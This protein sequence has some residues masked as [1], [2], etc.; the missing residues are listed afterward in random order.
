MIDA[1]KFGT[2][3]ELCEAVAAVDKDDA[4]WKKKAA[5][6]ALKPYDVEVARRTLSEVA[7]RMWTMMGPDI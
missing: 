3:A 2:P 5:V 1:R 7:K 6:P 4:L